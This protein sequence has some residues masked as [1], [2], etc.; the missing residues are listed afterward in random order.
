MIAVR[1]DQIFQIVFGHGHRI[2]RFI[3]G[4]LEIGD[5]RFRG[6]D[7]NRRQLSFIDQTFVVL[8]LCLGVADPVTL[9]LQISQGIGQVPISALHV[10]DDLDGPL[11][12]LRVG[13]REIALGD[14]D[15]PAVLIEPQ[16]PEQRLCQAERN[17]R[18]RLRA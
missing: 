6:D 12:E 17:V 8:E 11:A 10:G 5:L 15:R 13:K 1:R 16:T 18:I 2:E 4:L 14:L 9:N 7:V 3:N